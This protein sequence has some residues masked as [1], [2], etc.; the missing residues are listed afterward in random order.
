MNG[1][2]RV[3][4]AVG[5]D[6][7]ALRLRLMLEAEGAEVVVLGTEPPEDVALAVTV[8]ALAP[9][10]R[11]EAPGVQVVEL[12]EHEDWER[13]RAR[14]ADALVRGESES[15]RLAAGLAHARL[16][17]VDDSVTY[18]EYLRHQLAALGVGVTVCG[19]AEDALGHLAT[20]GGWDCVL[21]DLVMPGVDGIQLCGLAA[22]LRREAGHDHV[23]A[24]LSSRE[25]KDDLIRSLEA[26]ADLFLGK[27][28]D[29]SLIR[30]QLGALLRRRAL[31]R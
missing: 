19:S 27:S 16:L 17:L 29:I 4:L 3:L 18:R 28:Q 12:G 10:V 24:V 9:R 23:L 11:A 22:R 31:H 30:A 15:E 8:A 2:G 6:T 14:L 13:V 21:V 7:L 26:G 20:G 1:P 5:S 25:S